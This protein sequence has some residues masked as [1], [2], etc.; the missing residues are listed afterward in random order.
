MNILFL[1]TG[2]SC[3]SIIAEALLAHLSPASI[4]VQSAGS[5]PTGKVHPGALAV[6]QKNGVPTEGFCSKSWDNV[7]PLPDVVITLCGSAAGETCPVYFGKL[8]RVHWGMPDPAH[9]EGSEEIIEAAFDET[10]AV[11]QERIKKFL[12]LPLSELEKDE[13]ALQEHMEK[14]VE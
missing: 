7:D 11:L 13:K 10:F 6:L 8:V 12:A 5:Q 14:I 3:R 4:T 9:V 2:N 1:C